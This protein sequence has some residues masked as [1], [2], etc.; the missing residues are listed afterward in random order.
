MLPLS[1]CL[2]RGFPVPSSLLSFV[3]ASV[4]GLLMLKCLLSRKLF[5]CEQRRMRM[6][7]VRAGV[8]FHREDGRRNDVRAS[9]KVGEEVKGLSGMMGVSDGKMVTW[10]GRRWT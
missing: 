6:M 9:L 4:G 3:H 5:V 1:V 2:Y 10:A 7:R 8:F